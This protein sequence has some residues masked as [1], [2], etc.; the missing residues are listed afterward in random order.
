MANREE[1]FEPLSRLCGHLFTLVARWLKE[2]R[3]TVFERT[4]A[5]GFPWIE[6]SAANVI[7]GGWLVC[8]VG[9]AFP[10]GV[11]GFMPAVFAGVLGVA[12]LALG[13]NSGIRELVASPD[14]GEIDL[15]DIWFDEDHGRQE[16]EEE[17][18]ISESFVRPRVRPPGGGESLPLAETIG[19]VLASQ[20]RGAIRI[21][22]PD[23][24][25][26]TAALNYLARLIPAHMMVTYLERPDPIVLAQASHQGL[27]VFEF[28]SSD[29]WPNLIG[30][31]TL[32][33]WGRDEWIEYLLAGDRSRCA[34]VMTRLAACGREGDLLD[35]IPE[36]WAIALDIMADDELIDD[37]RQA[38]RI[39]LD[40]RLPEPVLRK[41]I[42]ADCL[43]VLA[44]H[45]KSHPHRM[46]RLRR[47]NPD[48]PLFRLIRHRATQLLLAADH[49][50][51]ALEQGIKCKALADPLPRDLVEEVAHR[52]ARRPELVARLVE[53]STGLDETIHP[54]VASL[55]HALRIGWKPGRPTPC[56][57]GAYLENASWPAI[58]LTD[59]DMRDVEL[60]GADLW[61]G[62]FDRARMGGARLSSADLRNASLC[63]SQL[64]RADLS[65]ARLARTR[66][67]DCRFESAMLA[68]ADLE[69]A[70]LDR[71]ILLSANLRDAKLAR[72][73]LVGGD[74]SDAEIDGADFSGADL[75]GAVM[76]GLK[77]TTA[78]FDGARF[79]GANLFHADL[80][81]I[82]LPRT[83]LS[84]ANLRQ[85]MLTGS[86]LPGANLRGANL[87]AAGLAEVE[88][89]GADLRGADLREVAFHLGSS[90]SG[91]VGSPI[92]CE[93]SRTGFY[94]DDYNEQD[95]KS[96][97]EIRK[98]NLVGVDLRGAN[99]DGVDFYLVDLR[100][101]KV[102]PK[103][104]PHLRSCG[105]ILASRD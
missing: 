14:L 73:S 1:W 92:A 105:A 100:G 33:P 27:V 89:E 25:G 39:E 62:Q 59:A 30:E 102:D 81:G 7:V 48:E 87:R 80:E 45:G 78:R 11:S 83:D 5:R 18:R 58:V 98:A 36:L 22:G 46:E 82:V 2:L 79:T 19:P 88:W 76:S 95:F 71:A 53:L 93:G 103:Q 94:S 54:M 3:R 70:L 20:E 101:A 37:P 67:K 8:V 74:L 28:E 38:L 41:Q 64:E 4:E 65:N 44:M 97:E 34:S 42:E 43:A 56:L 9:R 55:L 57:R 16:E 47:H 51:D 35:G 13:R 90:R 60:S 52:I 68:R 61:G 17:E 49:V 85:A 15:W 31:L 26:K 96:P 12:W 77:L 10:L 29:A 50:E 72:A 75:S 91:L 69:C 104:I 23:G 86:V 24:S 99:I 63:G 21:S 84:N 40:R 66:A 6:H 32:A